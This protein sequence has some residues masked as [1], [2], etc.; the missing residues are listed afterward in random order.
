MPLNFIF[1]ERGTAAVLLV[2]PVAHD[3]STSNY[4]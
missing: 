2:T 1:Q 4:T 3:G